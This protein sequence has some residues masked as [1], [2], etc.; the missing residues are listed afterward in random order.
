MDYFNYLIF[1][2]S[3]IILVVGL[4]TLVYPRY[5]QVSQEKEEAK[6]SLQVEYKT[7]SDYLDSI[8]NLK[9][10]YQL[11]NDEEKAKISS[12]LPATRDTSIII[13]EIESIAIKNSAILN[14]IKIEPQSTGSGTSSRTEAKEGKGSLAGI[15]NE[16][17]DGVG[18]VK[19]EIKLSSVNY[20]TLKNI[21][22][23]FE[24]NL[25]IFDIAKINFDV[26]KNEAL[27]N[28]Y[29]YYLQ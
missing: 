8:L 15:F 22:K 13:T 27:L 9:S 24:N 10:I 23:T 21:I 16:P 28:I 5:K 29:S 19:I 6:N 1:S 3:L 7:K 17:P 11:V 14:S 12:M 26:N 20:Q 2:F 18:L 25:R 4:L